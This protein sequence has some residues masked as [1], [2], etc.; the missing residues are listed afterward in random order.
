VR[1]WWLEPA[2]TIA[3]LWLVPLVLA[4]VALLEGRTLL[5]AIFAAWCLVGSRRVMPAARRL[6]AGWRATR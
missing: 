3:L 2:A 4:I 5:G 6:L 1:S